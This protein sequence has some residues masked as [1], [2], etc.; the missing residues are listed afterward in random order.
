[1]EKGSKKEEAKKNHCKK[2]EGRL[3]GEG[4]KKRGKKNNIHLWAIHPVWGGKPL[5]TKPEGERIKSSNN[6]MNHFSI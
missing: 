6:K 5:G 2:G 4:K 3:K 1:M